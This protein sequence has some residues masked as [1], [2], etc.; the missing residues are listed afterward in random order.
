MNSV[1]FFEHKVPAE[2]GLLLNFYHWE[3][4]DAIGA[5]VI[6]HGWSEHAGRYNDIASWFNE[7]GYAVYA[8]DHRGHG[9][10]EGKR[11]HVRRW[12]DYVH[13]L[14]LLRSRVKHE[15]QYLLGHSMGGMI[16]ILHA[17]EYPEQFS[18]MAL[19]GPA[20]DLSIPIP[21][22]KQFVGNAM[23]AWLPRLTMTNDIDPSVVCS[24]PDVV[25]DYVADPFT[26][27]KVTV[28]WFSE[29]MKMVER[30]KQDAV[31]IRTPIGIWHGEGDM[32][33]APWVSEEFYNRLTTPHRNRIIV[34]E[35]M[36]EILLEPS[37]PE[38]S[39]EIKNWFEQF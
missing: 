25:A 24:D 16:S 10:S 38:T 20:A 21:K 14:E 4:K 33:V 11:G 30:V 31:H 18:A 37:W 1:H 9:K 23:S 5:V 32:L 15:K 19:S 35:A 17:L 34:S 13:D 6:S 7:H 22:L 12:T 28:R 36:H 39:Q 8:L 27:G 29:Y 3:P 2:D 26:H